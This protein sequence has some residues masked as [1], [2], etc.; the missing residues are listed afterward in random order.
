VDRRSIILAVIPANQ[1]I[2]TVDI[3]ERAQSVDTSGQR[4][5]GVVTKCDLVSPGGEE[6]VISVIHNLR[7]PLALGYIALRNR[8][9]REI[10]ESITTSQARLIEQEFFHN[11]PVFRRVHA[12]NVGIQ[13]LSKKLTVLL[14]DRIKQEMVCTISTVSTVTIL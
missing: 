9:Q 11:H 10:N 5:I 12:Q 6:E 7:K 4:T 3:L 8:S 2:A 14:V 13:Q 1:D